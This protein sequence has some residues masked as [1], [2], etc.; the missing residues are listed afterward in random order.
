MSLQNLQ[1]QSS[2]PLTCLSVNIHTLHN[3]TTL[4]ELDLRAFA[5]RQG[6]LINLAI[7]STELTLMKFKVCYIL[8][9]PFF[10]LLTYTV[11]WRTARQIHFKS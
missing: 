3:V 7:I 4:R 1:L 10:M 6:S 5:S 11:E 2:V 8:F 9:L